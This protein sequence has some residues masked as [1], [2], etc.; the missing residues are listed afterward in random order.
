MTIAIY[1]PILA[2]LYVGLSVRTLLLRRS[3]KVG[4]GDGDSIELR[5]AIRAHSNFAEYVPISLILLYLLEA[6]GA[7]TLTIHVLCI[8]LILGRIS[9]AYAVSQQPEPLQFRVL[10]MALTFVAII[11]ASLRLLVLQIF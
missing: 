8:A 7:S 9:H 5:R 4:V 6:A 3:L 11:S 10:G 1:A 2:L